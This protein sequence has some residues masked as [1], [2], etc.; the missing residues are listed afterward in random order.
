MIPTKKKRERQTKPTR[1]DEMRTCGWRERQTQ[2]DKERQTRG[3]RG[4]STDE[5]KRERENRKIF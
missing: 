2:T 3:R 5:E 1:T 4:Q